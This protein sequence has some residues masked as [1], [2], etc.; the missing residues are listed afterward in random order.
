M[1]ILLTGKW[2]FLILG[3]GGTGI[4][5][6]KLLIINNFSNITVLDIDIIEL[7][8]LNRLFL[9]NK[10][11]IGKFK[12]KRL[13]SVYPNLKYVIID[14]NKIKVDLINMY[15]V[16]IVAV[17]NLQARFHINYL[18][19]FSNSQR[20]ID[21]GVFL[22]MCSVFS[23]TKDSF[24]LYCV[25]ELYDY[26]SDI[27]V[28]CTTQQEKE[29]LPSC[30]YINSICASLVIYIFKCKINY[31]YYNGAEK[32]YITKIDLQKDEFCIL[33]NLEKK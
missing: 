25:K 5:I 10:T 23:I 16:I 30:C 9:F 21:C 7:T 14:I 1:K 13:N 19:K 15:D 32:I 27:K 12:S 2:I 24:C 22:N 11:D 28:S 26:K 29:I 17:D 4:E 3:C 33:C 8:N 6:L 20:L 18:F 31:I